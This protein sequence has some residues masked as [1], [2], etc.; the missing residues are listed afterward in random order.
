M[1]SP[2]SPSSPPAS[3]RPSIRY[4]QNFL[5]DPR[6]VASLLDSLHLERESVVYEIGPGKGVMTRQLAWRYRQVVA[7]EKD[8]RLAGLLRRTF[9]DTPNVTIYQGDF[10]RFR[11]PRETYQV[12]A[13]I[14]FNITSAI[15]TKLAAAECPPEDAYLTMQREA[16]NMLLG[17]PRESL[18]TILLQPWFE[19]EVVHHFQRTDFTP[20][21]GVDIVM[22]RLRKRGPPLVRRADRQR[23]RDFVTYVFTTWQPTVE[24][25]LKHLCT[26][27]QFVSLRGGLDF[28]VDV[29]PTSLT[30]E[31]W[32]ALFASFQS[33]GDTRGMAAICGSEQ[34]LMRQQHTL[35]KT[36]R[37][38]ARQC[39]P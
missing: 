11:L 15:V 12:V 29:P 28:D 33:A 14:P 9:A 37:T 23:F 34:R 30:L 25:T 22:L 1:S 20:I 17:K 8:T 6:L 4:S 10:L 13:N 21:P 19:M 39:P 38:R 36:H 18:R 32:L 35:Q 5:R 27:R 2:S 26:R 16:A 24:R 3:L 7:I 31:Q